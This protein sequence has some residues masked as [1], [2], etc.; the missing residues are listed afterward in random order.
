MKKF[1]IHVVLVVFLLVFMQEVSA[2]SVSNQFTKTFIGNYHYVFSNGKY[3]D[4]EH[5]K[6]VGDDMIAYC[7]EPGVSFS[8]E[9]YE[10]YY[11][12]S[13]EQFAEKVQIS[14]EQV[15][16]I[17]LIAS[18]GWGYQN[19]YGNEWIVATQS[20][21]WQELGRDFQFTSRNKKENPWEYVIDTPKEIEEKMA[22]IQTLV[23]TYRA[24]PLFNTTHAKVSLNRSYRFVDS[25]SQVSSY[26]IKNCENCTA[27]IDGN[28]VEVRP[29]ENQNGKVV[30]EKN[31]NT[32]N[33]MYVIYYQ[34]AAQNLIV[35]GKVPE[36][37]IS[38]TYEIVKGSVQLTKYDADTK[39]CSP[40]A[41]GGSLKGSIY[42]LY[43]EDNTFV[44]DLVID[45][46]CQASFGELELG[47]YYIKE[48][49]PGN[50]Y[51]LDTTKYSF[52]VTADAPHYALTVYDK[53]D[54]GQVSIQKFDSK[55]NSCQ[56]TGVGATLK[57]A[58][59]GIYYRKDSLNS[60]LVQK[61]TVDENCSA[62]SKRNLAIGNYYL[63]ELEAPVG[64]LLDKTRHEFS[65]TKENVDEV[66][67]LTVQDEI[68]GSN[69]HIHKSFLSEMGNVPEKNASFAIFYA[70]TNI[71]YKTITTDA[72]GDATVWLPFGKYILKQLK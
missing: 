56:T 39:Y 25:T 48:Y 30:L 2:L 22:E 13:L 68:I 17:S 32:W 26:A 6:R 20:L 34:N 58:V 50:S 9:S 65:I 69:I 23:N 11:D 27:T 45:S 42:K 64:Y 40:K 67:N 53:M 21:I 52:E 38:L 14:K 15:E 47:K 28:S 33:S 7:I 3:G 61:I 44:T 49:Q 10:G 8:Q 19:H 24:N 46:N 18:Y 41:K 31:N 51:Q 66:L 55:T 54:L 71:K 5:I 12:L 35:P 72:S 29:I 62:L 43:K 16:K 60:I 57:G 36:K 37:N 1:I 4:F 59:Y 63:I 70:D